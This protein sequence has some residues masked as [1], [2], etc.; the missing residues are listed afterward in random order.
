MTLFRVPEGSCW[1]RFLLVMLVMLVVPYLISLLGLSLFNTY[2]AETGLNKQPL[3]HEPSQGK[4]L[5]GV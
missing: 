1:S 2:D 4:G 3:R 5:V